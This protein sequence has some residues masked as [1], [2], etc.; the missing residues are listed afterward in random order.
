MASD[1]F[2]LLQD[3]LDV[4]DGLELAAYRSLESFKANGLTTQPSA[5]YK[6]Q[7]VY[8][9][10]THTLGIIKIIQRRSSV[11]QGRR[12]RGWNP[13]QK[14]ARR[15][16]GGFAIDCATDALR[17]EEEGDGGEGGEE[18]VKSSCI[19]LVYKTHPFVGPLSHS[20]S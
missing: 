15:S 13:R 10:L 19:A 1:F 4:F 12:W 6:A 7:W 3:P 11:R 18:G 9:P 17:R 5:T 20:P 14:G 2:P 16:Q 8:I